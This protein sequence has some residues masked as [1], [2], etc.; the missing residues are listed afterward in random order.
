MKPTNILVFWLWLRRQYRYNGLE[1]VGDTKI[2]SGQAEKEKAAE[3]GIR[4]RGT[5]CL[6][7]ISLLSRLTGLRCRNVSHN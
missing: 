5:C 7:K 1:R 2:T 4:K 6:G 3:Q